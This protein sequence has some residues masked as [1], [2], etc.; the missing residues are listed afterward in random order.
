MNADL[1]P[2]PG[3]LPGGSQPTPTAPTAA[4]RE[5]LDHLHQLMPEPRLR[6]IQEIHAQVAVGVAPLEA[7]QSAAR[8]AQAHVSAREA[9]TAA[10]ASGKIQSGSQ[11]SDLYSEVYNSAMED[12]ETV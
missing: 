4:Y 9:V 10:L 3:V 5:A 12:P 8:Q 2:M 1:T 11:A 6:W 7:A